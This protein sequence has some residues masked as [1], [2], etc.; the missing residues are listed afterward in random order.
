[1]ENPIKFLKA[2]SSL[3]SG[4]EVSFEGD[5]T[6][7]AEFN[8]VRWKTGVDSEGISIDTTTNPHS[9]LTWTKVNNAMTTLQTAYDGVGAV[10]RKRAIEYAPLQEQLDLLYKDMAADKGDKT[11]EWF[12]AVKKVKDDNPKD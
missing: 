4:V 3:K 8:Q 11:G 6:T 1:M 9:E 7:E 2:I 12:K 5:I 10:Q